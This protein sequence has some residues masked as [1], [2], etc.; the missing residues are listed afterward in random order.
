[1]RRLR[2]TGLNPP[3]YYGRRIAFHINFSTGKALIGRGHIHI[4]RRPF[5]L[6]G[7]RSF[8]RLTA[9]RSS[10]GTRYILL[11]IEFLLQFIY[12]NFIDHGEAGSRTPRAFVERPVQLEPSV[13]PKHNI[14]SC[15]F[16]IAH[17]FHAGQ[18]LI[19]TTD[20]ISREDT[21]PPLN[22]NRQNR[23]PS[24]AIDPNLGSPSRGSPSQLR[25]QDTNKPAFLLLHGAWYVLAGWK[26]ESHCHECGTKT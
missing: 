4:R 21:E 14:S 8:I 16:R 20:I 1:M 3:K 15:I 9:A 12:S 19:S 2:R 5:A 17:T 24:D 13:T 18:L 11:A 23:T 25:A 6:V 26:K 10:E 7:I 22:Q